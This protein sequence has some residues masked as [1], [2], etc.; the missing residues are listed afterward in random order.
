MTNSLFQQMLVSLR[1]HVRI[2]YEKQKSLAKKLNNSKQ[3]AE[4]RNENLA[5]KDNEIRQMAQQINHLKRQLELEQLRLKLTLKDAKHAFKKEK[6]ELTNAME[7]AAAVHEKE[8]RALQK[9]LVESKHEVF[10]LKNRLEESVRETATVT[11]N[12]KN[13]YEDYLKLEDDLSIIEQHLIPIQKQ[14]QELAKAMNLEPEELHCRLDEL[15]KALSNSEKA[16][17]LKEVLVKTLLVADKD[18]V[19]PKDSN[20]AS[21]SGGSSGSAS[22]S[23]PQVK[24]CSSSEFEQNDPSCPFSQ[25]FFPEQLDNSAQKQTE[26]KDKREKGKLVWSK[27]GFK[28]PKFPLK[29]RKTR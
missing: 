13:F 22:F 28:I 6:I 17:N 23:E 27:L 20:I 10:Q 5:E 12:F 2:L 29:Q 11:E 9:A 26:K 18:E 4:H 8:K 1:I 3:T 7:K 19:T 24:P 16:G 21:S 15:N 14:F 25:K